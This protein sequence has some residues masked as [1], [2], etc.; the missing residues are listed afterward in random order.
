MAKRMPS[1]LDYGPAQTLYEVTASGESEFKITK[2]SEKKK[3]GLSKL[4]QNIQ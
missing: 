1:S 4:P 3:Q 2:P